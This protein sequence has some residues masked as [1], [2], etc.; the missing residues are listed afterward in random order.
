MQHVE[1][2]AA[3]SLVYYTH[4]G[5]AGLF[6]RTLPSGEE[7]RLTET[8]TSLTLNGW[9]LVGGKIWYISAADLH[10]MT[11][12]E[13]DPDTRGDRLVAQLAIELGE[14]NFSVGPDLKQVYLP[15]VSVE[16]SDIG[17]FELQRTA[18]H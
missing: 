18:A 1:V 9:H 14:F 8:I 10:S 16:D 13:F 15:R 6:R 11:L 12:R 5:T 3:R 17:A 7:Q 2:D 4:T